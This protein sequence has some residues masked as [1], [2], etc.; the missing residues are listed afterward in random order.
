MPGSGACATVIFRSK[1]EAAI[2]QETKLLWRL[3]QF[4]QK[5]WV[6]TSLFALL[7]AATALVAIPLGPLIPDRIV[8]LVG[9]KAVDRL[10][11]ILATSMLAVTTFSLQ[12]LVSA[13][14]AAANNATPRASVILNRDRTSQNILASFMGA[15]LF[16][17][18]GLVAL[19]TGIYSDGG[20]VLLFGATG[21]VILLVGGSLLRWFSHLTTFGRMGDTLARV[22]HAAGKPV[23]AYAQRPALGGCR[24]KGDPP[25][26]TH[27]VKAHRTG[28]IQHVDMQALGSASGEAGCR[29]W[30]MARPGDFIDPTETLI[31]HDYTGTDE[32]FENRLTAAVT[33]GNDRDLDQDPA[34]GLIILSEI[35]SR[36]LSPAVNDPGTAIDVLGR[37]VRLFNDLYKDEDPE[38]EHD[39]IFVVDVPPDA[40]F[41]VSFF[42]VARDGAELREVQVALLRALRT[43]ARTHPEALGVAARTMAAKALGFALESQPDHNVSEELKRLAVQVGRKRA[44]S[45]RSSDVRPRG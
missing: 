40:F 31:R 26:S 9:A 4:G 24:L 3:R 17:L 28:Y 22:E 16:S 32:K 10:L 20:L 8:D 43:I 1:G 15:F 11:G 12:V 38:I 33:I 7:G 25:L 41:R 45:A 39:N 36:A 44:A 19:Q 2:L 5:L 35:A 30:L 29:L 18:V 6:R 37:F 14:S 34:Y 27:T 23:K 13:L 42:P 21:S